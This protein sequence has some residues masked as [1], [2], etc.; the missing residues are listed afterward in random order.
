MARSAAPPWQLQLTNTIATARTGIANSS[1]RCADPAYHWPS[2]GHRNERKA[3]TDGDR[4]PPRTSA[5]KRAGVYHGASRCLF[6]VVRLPARPPPDLHHHEAAV[7]GQHL[8][9]DERGLVGGEEG[10]R[11]GDL[12]GRPEPTQRRA[13]R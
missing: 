3:A 5:F 12:L 1:A 8:A 7:D 6:M 10:D 2:P 4:R 13:R 11:V 9:R